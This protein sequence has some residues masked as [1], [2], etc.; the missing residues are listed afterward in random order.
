MDAAVCMHY[1]TVHNERGYY[2][3]ISA[4]LS[5]YIYRAITHR[6]VPL[7][8]NPNSNFST[9]TIPISLKNEKTLHRNKHNRLKIP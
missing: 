5:I 1:T 7:Q 8:S 3:A 2:I 9:R 4:W 6:P